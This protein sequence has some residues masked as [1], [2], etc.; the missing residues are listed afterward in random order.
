MGV[1]ETLL[2]LFRLVSSAFHLLFHT[3]EFVA[4]VGDAAV[5]EL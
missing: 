1:L 5:E 2:A 3:D 4:A